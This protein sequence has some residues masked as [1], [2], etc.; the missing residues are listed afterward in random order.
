M[1]PGVLSFLIV[2][3]LGLAWSAWAAWSHTGPTSALGWAATFLWTLPFPGSL[4][5]IVGGILTIRRVR[6]RRAR[7]AARPVEHETLIVVVPTIGRADTYP[8]L[9]RAVR[10]YCEHLPPMFPRLYIDIVVEEGCAASASIDGL[11]GP[12]V[13]VI[14]VPR[15]YRT[16]AGTRFKARAN[17]Y[18]NALRIVEHEA[19][20]DVWVLHMDDDTGVGPDTARAMAQFVN[21][22]QER[23]DQAFDL[24]QGVLTYPRENG[25]HRLLWLADAIRPASDVSTYAMTTGRGSP[26]T[27]LHGELLLVR[28]STEAAIGWD[29]GPRTMV[30]DAQ[31]A[32]NFVQRYPGRSDWFA[33]RSFGATPATVEDFLRQRERWAWGLLEL[34]FNHTIPI[35][36]RLP[37]I[38]N[39]TVWLFSP[40][41][42]VAVIVLAG[43]L[44]NDLDTVPATAVVLPLWC[45]NLGYHAWSYWEGLKINARASADT[46]RRWWE[47]GT[48]LAMLPAFSLLEAIGILRGFVRFIRHDASDFVVI[49]KPR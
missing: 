25:A 2:F 44:L 17:H 21:E 5:G 32:L 19:R 36:H 7:P 42:N 3:V 47:C 6:A 26:R 14:T 48:V 30:E 27:G 23:G 20:D 22:Q 29:Y 24:A 12:L 31:F 43:L 1:Q 45:A 34:A 33:G 11:A 15:H 39:V 18:A 8:A 38:H 41:Q 46:A 28:A 13:R 35:R 16:P 37:L 10:S 40:L 9:E 49:S 4:L